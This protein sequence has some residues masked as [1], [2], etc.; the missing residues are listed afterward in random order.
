MV[1][2]IL[3]RHYAPY[4]VRRNSKPWGGVASQRDGEDDLDSVMLCLSSFRRNRSQWSVKL[5]K[6]W[7]GPRQIALKSAARYLRLQSSENSDEQNSTTDYHFFAHAYPHSHP[8]SNVMNSVLNLTTISSN[9]NSMIPQT[10]SSTQIPLPPRDHGLHV[11]Q[12]FLTLR[13]NGVEV[14][15]TNFYKYVTTSPKRSVSSECFT[16]SVVNLLKSR[17]MQ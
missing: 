14:I 4:P 8:H 13:T 9:S 12:A 16:T 15:Q 17:T 5:E 7:E 11:I 3:I 10:S 2:M 6:F 1:K